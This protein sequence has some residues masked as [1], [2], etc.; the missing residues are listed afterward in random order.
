MAEFPNKLDVHLSGP[1]YEQ[2]R[3][4]YLVPTTTNVAG[5]ED[6]IIYYINPKREIPILFCCCLC[7]KVIKN[8]HGVPKH[9]KVCDVPVPVEVITQ[10]MWSPHKPI[11]QRMVDTMA[12]TTTDSLST[13]INKDID[14][15]TVLFGC[16]PESERTLNASAKTNFNLLQE[17]QNNQKNK[18]MVDTMAVD[19]DTPTFGSARESETSLNNSAKTNYNLPQDT[20]NNKKRKKPTAEPDIPMQTR[21]RKKMSSTQEVNNI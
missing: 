13:E 7:G 21:L 3:K 12:A 16:A 4:G 9:K 8:P 6:R 14:T 5:M 15:G 20:E 18:H 1:V 17:T 11:A 2:I 10:Q 19:T